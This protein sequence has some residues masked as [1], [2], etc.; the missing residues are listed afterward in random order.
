MHKSFEILV[1]DHK[2]VKHI[3]KDLMGTTATAKVKRQTMLALLKQELQL[4]EMIEEVH[5][6]PVLEKKQPTHDIALEGF[7][8][9]HEVDLLMAELEELPFNDKRWKAKLTVI[10][11]NLLH[12]I[13]EEETEMFPKA[14]QAVP[15]STLDKIA[16]QFLTAKSAAAKKL[17]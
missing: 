7:E 2:K 8:E 11:E 17:M 6:Y 5:L 4:H 10:Q 15:E 12:H 13:Q 1:K 16:D 9:H 14:E 3:L